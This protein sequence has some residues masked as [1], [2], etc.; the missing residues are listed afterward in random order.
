MVVEE[1]DVSEPQN[2]SK[3]DKDDDDYIDPSESKAKK[4]KPS[5]G[6]S[7]I[8]SESY[9]R[10]EDLLR[11]TE[12]F[13]KNLNVGTSSSPSKKT[14]TKVGDNRHRKTE[15]EE[16]EELLA[17]EEQSSSVFM[18]TQS[19]PYIHGTL[20]D[21]Q[22]RGV[23]WLIN[24]HHNG[25]NGILA[26]EM[27]LGKTLQTISLLGY[28]K[29]FKKINGPF[30]IIVPKSTLQNWINEI[31][32]WCPTLKAVS[33]IGDESTRNTI[34]KEQ[35][36]TNEF[37]ILATSYEMVLKTS[38]VLKKFVW[39]FIVIDEA[40]RIKNE[41][42][43]L[44]E[45]VRQLN[46]VN[47][48]L[49]TGTPLQ[50][51]LH[52]LWALLNFLLPDLFGNSEDFDSWFSNES[53]LGNN[54]EIVQ[55]LHKVLQP[56]LLRR[57]KSDVEKSL[58]PKK[59]LKVYV[60]LSNMQR[61]WY[62]KILM[63]ELDIING[64]GK[65]EKTRMM[66]ILMHLRKC[67]NHP[68]LFD[69][70]EPG[71][72]YT[73]DKHLVDNCGKM[74]LLDKLLA[75]LKDQGSR[76]LIFSQMSRMLD[77]LEDYCWWRGYQYCRLDGQ[78]SHE[79]RQRSIDEYN[80]PG[81]EKF[82]FM[83]TTRA[84]GLGINLTTADVVII[85][86]SDW[87]P[88][89]D[90]QAMDRAHRIGQKKQ[91]RVFRLITEDTV[92]ERI[93]EKAEMKLYLDNIVIQQG[94]LTE[95]QKTLGKDEMLSMI[96]HGADAV[97]ASKDATITDDDIDTILAKAEE[98]TEQLNNKLKQFGESTLRSM[99]FDTEEGKEDGKK[100]NVYSFE[101]EDYKE[102][103]KQ[104]SGLP[105]FWIEPPKRERKQC[106]ELDKIFNDT[107][108]TK[109]SNKP[110]RSKNQPDIKEFQFYP[111]R[112]YQLVEKENLYYRKTI[113]WKVPLPTNISNP[114]EALKKQKAEQKKIDNAKPLTKSE[115]AEK[116]RL[117]Q[118][119]FPAWTKGEFLAFVRGCEKYGRKDIQSI[120]QDIPSKTFQEV[121]EYSKT[122][123][124]KVHLLKDKD[125]IL[126]NVKKGENRLKKTKGVQKAIDKA[127]SDSVQPLEQLN[128][129]SA[130]HRQKLFLPEDDRFLLVQMSEIG[131]HNEAAPEL[132][133]EK[134]RTIP[135]YRLDFRMLSRTPEDI[136]V[137][138]NQ[139]LSVMERNMNKK[140]EWV[141]F[142]DIAKQCEKHHEELEG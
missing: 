36:M 129:F 74:V 61:E 1:M 26:D 32:R 130:G 42:S 20:R 131:W 30:L 90:L 65:V 22:I 49:I 50:N 140:A 24:L 137:R 110:P 128:L 136:K 44:S 8:P 93:I 111:K 19:P 99:T 100:F 79:D 28:M 98:K 5:L 64:A 27:G 109:K 87:N 89:M 76:V 58:L 120:A 67:C 4:S 107:K 62:T 21:Y 11:K 52:E 73:T 116:E 103:Q 54:E 55:R 125:K 10:F 13:S 18:F 135:R 119:G 81:S 97:I 7:D 123:W 48:L 78:T 96:R 71:P 68:Y 25:I 16:D 82:I 37:D 121:E 127:I 47:R 114:R 133:C 75:K 33:L 118:E 56:F 53:C 41:K 43:K 38:S 138:V 105:E 113:D 34:I 84:G 134:I 2:E 23:N 77:L 12:S 132:I 108:K 70:A 51:N 141:K 102:K 80:A 6:L 60:G 9:K 104:K 115:Q 69:G 124:V 112:C 91:V 86:D 17:A 72:P 106:Y 88:Q 139:L 94:R 45:M 35:I 126:S 46:S 101:G 40:H 29:H 95:A 15:K 142:K 63:K 57:L 3:V 85:Y 31:N 14:K 83:L 59:E 92:D 39:Q 66:N 122:F 117:L